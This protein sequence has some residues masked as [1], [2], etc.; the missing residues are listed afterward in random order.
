MV[1]E[2]QLPGGTPFK[3]IVAAVGMIMTLATLVISFFPSSE[4]D[5]QANM[6]YQL[7]LV[8]CFAISIALPFIIY[9]LR[10]KWGA[11]DSASDENSPDEVATTSQTTGDSPR[12]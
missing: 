4:L 3:A 5:A 6:V 11:E 9:A 12:V 2:F 7:T 8:V 1:R 10:T